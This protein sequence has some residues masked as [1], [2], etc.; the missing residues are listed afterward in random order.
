VRGNVALLAGAA[1]GAL[2]GALLRRR[3]PEIAPSE[4]DPR[5]EELRRKLAHARETVADE[6][7]FEVAGMAAETMVE[8]PG[9]DRADADVAEARRRVHREARATAEEMRD[10][11]SPESS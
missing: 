7:D 6:E 11:T 2:A 3:R 1:A 8:E 5:A 4:T 9:P 10:S